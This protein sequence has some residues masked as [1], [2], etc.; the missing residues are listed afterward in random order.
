MAPG[1]EFLVARSSTEAEREGG[2]AVSTGDVVKPLSAINAS[3]VRMFAIP[4]I[5]R[6]FINMACPA[7]PCPCLACLYM[8]L[9]LS[10]MPYTSEETPL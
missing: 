7:L 1:A 6:E 10:K 8:S 2:G 9:F 3:L 4:L 5:H